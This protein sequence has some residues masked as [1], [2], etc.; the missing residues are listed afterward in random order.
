MRKQHRGKAMRKQ[1]IRFGGRG[2]GRPLDQF[3]YGKRMCHI[4]NDYRTISDAN[5]KAR[6]LENEGIL[7]VVKKWYS[8]I[9]VYRCGAR[10]R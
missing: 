9:V 7:V 10:K 4:V 3:R 6:Q 1:H 8:R 2:S 5:R